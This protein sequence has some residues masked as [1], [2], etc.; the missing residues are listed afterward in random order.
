MV[1]GGPTSVSVLVT[2]ST[3]FIGSSLVSHLAREGHAVT[4]LVRREAPSPHPQ[5]SWDPEAGSIDA[6]RLTDIDAVVHLAG[7]SISNGRWTAGRKARIR[8]SRVKGTLLLSQALAGLDPRPGVL[9][10]A[11]AFGYYGDRGDE[12]L[13]EESEPGSDFLAEVTRQW[14]ASTRPASE[15]GIRTVNARF[16]M[17]LDAS[18]GAL[19]RMLLPFRLGLGARL[20]SGTQYVSWVSLE[21]TVRALSHVLTDDS[22]AGPVNVTAPGAVTNSEFT[23]A[24]GRALSRPAVLRAPGPLLRVLFGELAGSLTASARMEPARLLESGFVFRHP[25]LEDA[26]GAALGRT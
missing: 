14:E 3:G 9:I 4:H 25:R 7:E 26:L 21:D 1:I 6:D 23:R 10:S 22:L 12:V 8:D 20:G 24:L 18:G 17:V 13:R 15:A 2:G 16:A 19:A 11:S 5:V